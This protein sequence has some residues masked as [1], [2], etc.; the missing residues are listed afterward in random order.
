ML[1]S[2]TLTSAQSLADLLDRG[3][4]LSM[5]KAMAL[6]RDLAVEVS[7]LH[8]QGKSHGGIESAAVTLDEHF[9]PSLAGR[10][11]EARRRDAWEWSPF[12]LRPPLPERLLTR[13]Q[14]DLSWSPLATD[15]PSSDSSEAEV[16]P[17]RRDVYALAAL[18]CRLV[19]GKSADAYL[20]SPRVK[21]S[22]PIPLQRLLDRALGGASG[23]RIDDADRFLAALEHASTSGP[24]GSGAT[25]ETRA[26]PVPPG[27]GDEEAAALEVIEATPS[28]ISGVDLARGGTDRKAALADDEPLPFKALGHYEIISRLGEGGMGEV[29]LG[30]ERGLDRQV[31]IKVLPAKLARDA[32]L[33]RRFRA[34]AT[35]AAKLVHPNI[36]Q[37]YYI[38]EDAGHHFFAM[39][40]VDG[41]SLA[42]LLSQGRRLSLDES[43]AIVDE[44]LS[45]LV[46]AHNLGFVHRDIK[47]A[48]I[49][50]DRV[51][52]RA[53]LA[54]FGLV[55][56]LEESVMSKT[57]TGVVLGTVDY[58]APEQ[59]QGKDVDCRS[60]LYSLGVVMYQL[61]SGRL[62]FVARDSMAVIYQHVHEPLP[63]LTNFAPDLPAALT[64]VVEKL[65]AKNPDDRYQ[66][67][68]EALA[69]V[70]ALRSG[71]PIST[72][73]P[74]A[75]GQSTL[76]GGRAGTASAPA[77]AAAPP[78]GAVGHG[79]RR[80]LAALAAMALPAAAGGF[81]FALT[82][83][84]KRPR[85][86]GGLPES[87]R[88]PGL[89]REFGNHPSELNGFA[90]TPDEQLLIVADRT[91]KLH[92]WDFRMVEK[93]RDI[94]AHGGA[95]RRV[96]V[97]R[98]GKHAITA[99]ADQTLKLWDLANW[100]PV[101]QFNGHV[102]LVMSVAEV[103][104]RDE[105]VSSS[106]DCTLIRWKRDRTGRKIMSYG[107]PVGDDDRPDLHAID[108]ASLEQHVSWIRN[109]V[110]LPS[111]DR[112]V[113][114]GNDG[115]IL[116]WD[117]DSGRVIDRLVGHPTVF[118]S[119]ALSPDGDRIL[120]GGY[121]KQISL[122]DLGKRE[123]IH[124][125][126][127]DSSTPATVAFAPEGRRAVSG[128]ADGL[129][130]LW[131]LA[132]GRELY[133]IEGHEG[134][135]SWAQFLADGR[136]VVTSGEDRAVRVWKLPPV[137]L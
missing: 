14:G 58:I 121:D 102:D 71:H 123:I 80:F 90:L 43:L 68:A 52:R 21:G 131:D 33:I 51:H 47:P 67:A 72:A 64:G 12:S 40:H 65:L 20:R 59:G 4:T 132:T 99:S 19:T 125:L 30:Y 66:S 34:E 17:R 108:L 93:R 122:W 7:T 69:D 38:G 55:K 105:I 106:S 35:A 5:P 13:F 130:H 112:I 77:G 56:S 39:Q 117:L 2:N 113:S 114:A 3:Q 107:A 89:I 61:L 74:S 1:A 32:D 11:G 54:D 78:V 120:A 26:V 137:A 48:N 126:P 57:S 28:C 127:H 103:P 49:L 60:D 81:W 18:L 116:V 129:I 100:K 37:I 119:L 84:H 101:T 118:M 50:L 133:T 62:P 24:A 92:L 94:R 136:H 91:G 63:P 115:A 46:A 124:R 73:S 6:I 104:G 9:R 97:T 86:L 75:F 109:V 22:L 41:M 135:V 42:R 27:N 88:M 95:V 128:G 31:A 23:E 79:R 8:R 25:G 85:W 134:T 96:I 111:G 87:A 10:R 53:L 70:R 16:D 110:V 82:P 44:V 15:R 36:I 98:D 83:S 76:P 29:Y 45:G